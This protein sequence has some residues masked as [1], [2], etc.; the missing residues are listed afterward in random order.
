M[1]LVLD[2]GGLTNVTNVTK[3]NIFSIK[4]DGNKRKDRYLQ[5]LHRKWSPLYVKKI[6]NSKRL[7]GKHRLEKQDDT[8]R[9]GDTNDFQSYRD[10]SCSMHVSESEGW[11]STGKQVLY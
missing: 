11:I 9:E 8:T 10:S 6:K 1:S 3:D 5:I 4:I 2:V 7:G